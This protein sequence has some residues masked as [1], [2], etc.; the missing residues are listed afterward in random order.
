MEYGL[1]EN[2]VIEALTKTPATTLGVYDK[3]GSLDAGKLG[4]FLI[5]NGPIFSEKSIILQN[6][7]QGIKYT[8]KEDAASVAGTY[9]LTV[10][11]PS[12]TEKYTLDVK[13]AS[14]VTMYAK[15]H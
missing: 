1:S 4:N 8:V 12:G 10:N 7:V 13:S 9:A 6:W 11:T 3:V 14:S 2:K 15:I 5:T